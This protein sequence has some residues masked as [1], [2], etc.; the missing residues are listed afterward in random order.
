[1]TTV[2]A[3]GG[4]LWRARDDGAVEVALVHRPKYD[5]WSL[6]KGKLDDAEHPLA[7]ALREIAEETGFAAVPGRPLGELRY[8]AFGAPKRVRYW[9]CRAASGAFVP[10]REVDALAW[11]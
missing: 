11:A 5:D 10:G 8:L 9:S 6:P 2:E 3:A 1:M 4:V 7:C